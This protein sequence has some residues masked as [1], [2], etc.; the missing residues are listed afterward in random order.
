MWLFAFALVVSVTSLGCAD[1]RY[2]ATLDSVL[3]DQLTEKQLSERL[4]MEFRVYDRTEPNWKDL[5]EFLAREPASNFGPLR[6]TVKKY[7]RILY[8]T[9]AWTMT[10]IFIDEQGIAREYFLS[11]Q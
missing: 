1:L 2:R 9:T 11:S 3:R 6:E 10:W 8:H 7:P 4:N 5:Q